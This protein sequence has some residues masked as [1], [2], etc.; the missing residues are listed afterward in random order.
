QDLDEALTL[1]EANVSAEKKI[2]LK[3]QL[4]ILEE[5]YQATFMY[6]SHLIE[7]KNVAPVK[8]ESN[9][10]SM[11]LHKILKPFQLT[12]DQIGDRSFIILQAK[13]EEFLNDEEVTGTVTEAG[14]G[15]V[16]A[17][18]NI[19][20]K[21]TTIGTTTDSDGEFELMVSSLQD[22][23]MFSFVGFQT[24]EVPLNGRS[25]LTV[26]LQSQAVSGEEV[27]VVGYGTQ[28][29]AD[30]TSSIATVDVEKVFEARP[31]SEIGSGLQGSVAGLTVRNST[32]EIGTNP[33]ITLRG[34][35]GSLNAPGA[36]PLIL[37]DG[38][39]VPSLN[40][41]NTHDV[42]SISVLKD[43]AS[44]AI[45]GTEAA[46]GAILITTK[47]GERNM[48]PQVSYSSNFSFSTPTAVP[49]VAPAADG[50]EMAFSALQRIDPST[51]V[52]GVVGMYFDQEGIQKM[53]EWEE[54]Y[55]GQ[56]LS[57]EMV[58]GRDFEIRDGRLFFYRPWDAG[59]KY[60]R[61]WTPSQE[62]YLNVAGG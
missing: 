8:G 39:K 34:L 7:D 22:T 6:Q 17:G 10:L 3:K 60:L 45:Y 31:I 44:T 2:P 21:G 23:L 9:K 52:F 38:V 48:E 14:A 62:L 26:S 16:L 59:D 42:E 35:Q 12:Y 47:S 19:M 55:G 28:Q 15:D 53:R 54:Q 46:W 50:A 37:V 49:E 36:Q 25:S 41:V 61:D 24:K 30:L 20:V 1:R 11:V 43:A 13:T 57:D 4:K 29:R 40:Q 56:N 32:G 5:E 18:V 27:V 51:D 33:S 58:M